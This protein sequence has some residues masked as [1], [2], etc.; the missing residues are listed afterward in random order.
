M[1]NDAGT[2]RSLAPYLARQA[3]DW[4]LL[5]I[6][7]QGSNAT[8]HGDLPFL[9]AYLISSDMYST[10][11]SATEL[12]IVVVIS[13]PLIQLIISLGHSQSCCITP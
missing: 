13:A 12:A 9:P 11:Y 3:R 2:C 5:P 6:I 4:S 7:T 10:E 8:E 1:C